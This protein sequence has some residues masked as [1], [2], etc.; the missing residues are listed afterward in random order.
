MSQMYIGEL[1]QQEHNR[2]LFI[3][4]AVENSNVML[5]WKWA[6]HDLQQIMLADMLQSEAYADVFDFYLAQIMLFSEL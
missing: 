6:N 2:P 4:T 3:T 5:R 1:L